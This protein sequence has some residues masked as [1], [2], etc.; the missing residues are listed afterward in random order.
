MFTSEHFNEISFKQQAIS[1]NLSIF[2]PEHLN[3]FP[4]MPDF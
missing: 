3:Y 4:I 1:L 2:E